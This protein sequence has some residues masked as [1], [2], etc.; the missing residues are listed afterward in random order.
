M[1]SWIA[2]R[3]LY[4]TLTR[5]GCQTRLRGA[6]SWGLGIRGWAERVPDAPPV[7]LPAILLC[8]ALGENAF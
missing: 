7:Q 4:G 8:A 5:F 3:G 2:L 1:L 6:G